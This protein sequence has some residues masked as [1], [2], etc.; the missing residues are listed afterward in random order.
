MWG[1]RRLQRRRQAD[2]AALGPLGI[3]QTSDEATV[4]RR[5]I[6]LLFYLTG[7]TILLIGSARPEMMLD[8]PRISGTVVLAFDISSS[9]TA[10]DLDPTRIE[11]A[12]EAARAFVLNQPPTIDLSVVAFSNGGL[13]VQPP[14]R[15]QT[16]VLAAI[17]RLSPQGNTSLGQGIFTALNAIADEPLTI[18]PEAMTADIPPPE[19]SSYSS[20]VVILLTDG[21]NTAQPDPLEIAQLAAETGV[22]IYPV[23]IGS[24]EGSVIEVEGFQILTQL[25]PTNLEAIANLTNGEYFQAA[26]ADALQEIYK[27]IDLQLTI[28][29]EKMEVTAVFAGISLLF[30]LAG[31]LLSMIW[32]NRIP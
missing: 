22:R 8:L 19:L 3:M 10:D 2:R 16:A 25:D 13:V 26:D 28:E 29:G 7:L 15:D 32:F 11:A 12:K 17:D 23:G 20:A 24:E 4:R 5:R 21:E 18:D 30:F 6:P 9:M 31:G 27:N 1:Y 14:T